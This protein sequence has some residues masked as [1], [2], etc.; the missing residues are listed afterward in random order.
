MDLDVA[1]APLPYARLANR[2]FTLEWELAYDDGSPDGAPDTVTDVTAA[3]VTAVLQVARGITPPSP[4]VWD[5]TSGASFYT[6]ED[7]V[8]PVLQ[9]LEPVGLDPGVYDLKVSFVRSAGFTDWVLKAVLD[10]AVQ[11]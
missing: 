9:V 6:A 1:Q 11:P 7:G 5:L 10:L 2:P 4:K 3:R 8:T